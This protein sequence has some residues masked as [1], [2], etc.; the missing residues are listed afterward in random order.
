MSIQLIYKYWIKT[1]VNTRNY[2]F[3]GSLNLAVQT[4]TGSDQILRRIRI[5]RYFENRIRQNTRFCCPDIEPTFSKTY[6]NENEYMFFSFNI[7]SL[8]FSE[9]ILSVNDND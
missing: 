7:V 4:G 8:F 6:Y 2:H 3:R 9:V 5:Q 1:L